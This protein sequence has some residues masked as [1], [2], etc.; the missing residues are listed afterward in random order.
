MSV[1]FRDDAESTPP[2]KTQDP[3][4]GNDEEKKDLEDDGL[5]DR[6]RRRRTS[7]AAGQVKHSKLGWKRL[8]VGYPC[9]PLTSFRAS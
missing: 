6:A 2:E 9:T 5:D 8:T 3:I 1:Q 7:I 4:W